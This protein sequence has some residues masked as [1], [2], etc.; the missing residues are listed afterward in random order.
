MFALSRDIDIASDAICINYSYGKSGAFLHRE[1]L[2]VGIYIF[3]AIL[4]I[5]TPHAIVKG[6]VHT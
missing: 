2:I 6:P 1:Y 3:L 4:H 5:N